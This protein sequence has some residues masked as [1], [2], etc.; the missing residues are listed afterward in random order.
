MTERNPKNYAEE[1]FEEYFE[2]QVEGQI[3][4]DDLDDK[5]SYSIAGISLTEIDEEKLHKYAQERKI[6]PKLRKEVLE[7]KNRIRNKKLNEDTSQTKL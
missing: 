2:E 1:F 4:V 6:A 7:E 3:G 5:E